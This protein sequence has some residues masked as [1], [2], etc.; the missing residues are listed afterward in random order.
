MSGLGFWQWFHYFH[1]TSSYFP[2]FSLF[3]LVSVASQLLCR[4]LALQFISLI[5][6]ISFINK[7]YHS[8]NNNHHRHQGSFRIYNKSYSSHMAVESG[9]SNAKKGR[10]RWGQFLIWMRLENNVKQW[11]LGFRH[12]LPKGNEVVDSLKP[13]GE[14]IDKKCIWKHRSNFC[15]RL[16]F[17][18]T[19][20][21]PQMS[22]FQILVYV[23]HIQGEPILYI[24]LYSVL[25]LFSTT[26]GKSCLR[27]LNERISKKQLTTT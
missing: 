19:L 10:S 14:L 27:M 17:P 5:L 25:M 26:R 12:A 6:Y 22:T 3:I 7:S 18:A 2:F 13:N 20:S 1:L 9:S 23:Y 8:N 4:L 21:L 11:R 16:F 24:S 15:L